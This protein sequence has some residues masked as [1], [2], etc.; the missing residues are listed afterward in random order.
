MS[1]PRSLLYEI[2]QRVA[3]R[4]VVTGVPLQTLKLLPS[5]CGATKRSPGRV[6]HTGLRRHP[7]GQRHRLT[8]T[9]VAIAV[10]ILLV[11]LFLA[12]GTIMC[13]LIVASRADE[14]QET[15]NEIERLLCERKKRD[16]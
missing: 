9:L 16:E 11:L 1:H 8:R 7:R 2:I 14:I 15:Q 10:A 3:G 13:A 12:A 4:I 6:T 5:K